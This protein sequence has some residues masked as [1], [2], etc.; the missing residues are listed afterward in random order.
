MILLKVIFLGK[1]LELK[2]F[3]PTFA[4]LKLKGKNAYYTTTR[5]K[6]KD[7]NSC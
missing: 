5:K 4:V 3:N 7:D 2:E 6:R 1:K